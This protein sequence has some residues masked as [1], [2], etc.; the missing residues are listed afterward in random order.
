MGD[1]HPSRSHQLNNIT[2]FSN[3]CH[4][5]H[6]HKVGKGSVSVKG[7]QRRPLGGGD[8]AAEIQTMEGK[9]TAMWP[10]K[11]ELPRQREQKD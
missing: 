2:S 8:R 10:S 4:K 9:E 11:Q 1:G 3:R 7:G 6:I 5:I